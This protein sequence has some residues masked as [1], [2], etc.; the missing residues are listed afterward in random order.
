M[1]V[2]E[3]IRAARPP[4]HDAEPDEALLPSVRARPVPR[5][6][7]RRVAIPAVAVVAA[8]V[9]AFVTLGGDRPDT[10]SAL[11]EAM[12]WFDPPA[13]TVVHSALVDDTGRTREFW[14]DVDD[15]ER[16]R[17]VEPN[18]Y[19]T[20]EG[21]IYDPATNTIYTDAGTRVPGK[22]PDAKVVSDGAQYD[23]LLERKES[24]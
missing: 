18:G 17:I 23:A 3:R 22:G 7:R 11:S 19:E 1:D 6:P 14:Q 20:S 24:R 12:R 2:D 15:L 10:A 13:G 9:A 16:S 8:A 21:A 5:R 4:L